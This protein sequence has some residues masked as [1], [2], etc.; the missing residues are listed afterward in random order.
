MLQYNFAQDTNC[1]CWSHLSV[2]SAWGSNL[3]V[4][5]VNRRNNYSKTFIAFIAEYNRK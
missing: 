3:F 2:V 4:T 5:S 1:G